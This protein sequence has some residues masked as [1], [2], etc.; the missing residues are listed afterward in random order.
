MINRRHD[1]RASCL[2]RHSLKLLLQ[3]SR[4]FTRPLLGKA[5][6]RVEGTDVH[7]NA[8]AG[9]GGPGYFRFNL[10]P[11]PLGVSLGGVD[12]NPTLEVSE[13][14][15]PL[16]RAADVWTQIEKILV[17]INSLPHNR[18]TLAKDGLSPL[19]AA[20]KKLQEIRSGIIGVPKRTDF[21]GPKL[22]LRVVGPPN[23]VYGGEW[24]FEGD[25]LDNLDRAFSRIYR[26]SA[27]RKVVLRDM[28]RELLAISAEWNEVTEIWAL[29]LPEAETL[30]GFAG[31]A[32]PQKLF[33]GV[34]LTEKGNRML[35]GNATQIFF[36]V[37][38]P[39]WVTI[40]QKLL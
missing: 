16:S 26:N 27:E 3:W 5:D 38:N 7:P 12:P 23:R 18:V 32:S 28:L 37:K 24:W 31:S 17:D 15:C 39:L 20:K 2:A 25:L 22:F 8:P 30:V 14:A 6:M 36:P 10:P 19:A 13:A 11:G 1:G 40:H 21:N 29:D 9:S 4:E 33:G 35:V 34:P